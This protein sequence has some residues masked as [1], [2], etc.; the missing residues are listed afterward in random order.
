MGEIVHDVPAVGFTLVIK[1][2]KGELNLVHRVCHRLLQREVTPRP[3]RQ[4][5]L[6]VETS[7][8]PGTPGCVLDAQQFIRMIRNG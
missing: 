6:K 7:E 2:P 5:P 1:D 4:C 3:C 8:G